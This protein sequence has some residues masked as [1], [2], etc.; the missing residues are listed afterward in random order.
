VRKKVLPLLDGE[1][2]AWLAKACEPILG[3]TP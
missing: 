3:A 2:A 1:A